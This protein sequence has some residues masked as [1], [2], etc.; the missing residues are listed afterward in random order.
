MGAIRRVRDDGRVSVRA[1]IDPRAKKLADKIIA[2]NEIDATIADEKQ[3]LIDAEIERAKNFSI[4][5]LYDAWIKDGVARSDGNKYITQ[6][7]NKHALPLLGKVYVRDLTE[8]DLR[9]LYRKIILGGTVATAVEL[10]KDI[11]QMLRRHLLKEG[12]QA[13]TLICET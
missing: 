2:Q 8:H 4:Q 7:L 11:G 10:S 9:D 5:N 3:K 13:K 1:G 6:S 12:Y